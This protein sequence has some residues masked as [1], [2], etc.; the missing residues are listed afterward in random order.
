M[1]ISLFQGRDLGC[2]TVLKQ[3]VFSKCSYECFSVTI[4][5]LSQEGNDCIYKLHSECTF[6]CLCL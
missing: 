5:A 2:A 6:Q 1:A 3:S 4:S